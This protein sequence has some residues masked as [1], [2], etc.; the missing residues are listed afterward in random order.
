MIR[1]VF[2]TNKKLSY[3]SSVEST[4]DDS[5][6]LTVL[7]VRGQNITGVETI[8]NPY[9]H[10]KDG[11]VKACKENKLGVLISPSGQC[12][13]VQKLKKNGISVYRTDDHKSVLDTFN[14]FIQ[15]K[16]EKVS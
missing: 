15:D 5:E 9:L 11:M 8:N 3:I 2:P 10:S 16:L 12:L 14:D 6:Y 7:N 13:P 1:I 4:F